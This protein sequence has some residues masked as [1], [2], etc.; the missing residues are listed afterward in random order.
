M[1]G[2]VAFCALVSL[3]AVLLSFAGLRHVENVVNDLK[4]QT[5]V[6]PKSVSALSSAAEQFALIPP[7]RVAQQSNAEVL[8]S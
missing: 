8:R 2:Y 1:A 4:R 3:P 6:I 5:D 7:R